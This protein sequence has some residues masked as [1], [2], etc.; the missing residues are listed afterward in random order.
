ML[1]EMR[2]E[3][4]ILPMSLFRSRNFTLASV[5]GFLVGFGMFGAVT[6]LPQFQQLVQGASATNSGLL[7][8]PM[9]MGML[10]TTMTVG[11]LVTRTGRYR[12]YPI[13]GGVVMTAGMLLL[14]RLTVDSTQLTTGLFML[15]L[16]A[17]MGFLMQNTMLI[18]QNSVEMK[19]MGAASGAATLF[20]TIGGS[21]GVSILGAVYSSRL[22]GGLSDRLGE[23]AASRSPAAAGG[24]PRRC[25]SGCRPTC[26]APWSTRWPPASTTSS[27]GH[28]RSP[29]WPSSQPGSSARPRCAAVPRSGPPRR[30][31]RSPNPSRSDPAASGQGPSSSTTASAAPLARPPRPGSNLSL[32]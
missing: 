23:R 22:T 10:F 3:S 19:D 2:A 21:L 1:W 14:S 24:S 12:V 13:V 15:V 29:C 16:G 9:M 28:P 7:L 4:P 27:S 17:G 11:Q 6:F 20:R 25:S 26:A 31:A 30:T 8:L 5:L 32:T 18:A